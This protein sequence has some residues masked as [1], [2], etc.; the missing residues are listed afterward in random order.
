MVCSCLSASKLALNGLIVEVV[1]CYIPTIVSYRFL[2]FAFLTVFTTTQTA[3]T[4]LT[5]TSLN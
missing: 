3:T 1:F 2:F 5:F 4:D